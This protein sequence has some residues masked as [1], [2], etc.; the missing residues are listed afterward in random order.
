M[1]RPRVLLAVL[2]HETNTFVPGRTRW[3]DFTV[4]EGNAILGRMD[5]GSPTAGFLEEA[6]QQD[7]EVVPTIEARAAPSG[8]VDDE[9]FERYWQILKD[10]TA[11][12]LAGRID[13]IYLILHGAMATPMLRDVEGELLSRLRA[14]PG[15]ARLP[16]FGV[17]DLHANVSARMCACADALVTYRENP[18]TDASETARRV[19]RMLVRCLAT[20]ELPKTIQWQLPVLLAPSA[21]GTSRDPMLSLEIFARQAEAD[22]AVWACNVAAGFAYCDCEDAGLS[23]TLVSTLPA[24]EAD[25]ILRR[26]ADIAWQLRASSVL[27]H[28]TVDEVI[29]NLLPATGKPVLLV[30]PADNIG[31]GA[32]GDGTAVLR[33]FLKHKVEGTLVIINAPDAVRTLE[34]VAL[35]AQAVIKLRGLCESGD[36][37]E[38]SVQVISRSNGHFVLEDRQSHLASMQGIHI[39]MGPCAVVRCAGT[40]LLL[41][42]RAT[43]PFDLGQLRSQGLEP[44]KFKVIAVKAAVAHRRAYD[45]IAGSS[46]TV[47]TP[48]PCASNLASFAW[49]HLRRPI[50]PLDEF[51]DSFPPRAR[52]ADSAAEAT[53]SSPR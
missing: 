29:A 30:E 47:E 14:L 43:P 23:L 53:P 24:A 8:L 3:K 1:T 26:G 51:E 49:R 42:S 34:V 33:S 32:P 50:F 11:R 15:A 37:L 44:G 48:G 4:R 41:T 38:L 12:Q 27:R 21:T 17:L 16:I 7:F 40:T 22:P 25:A 20:G 6:R 2:F 52:N 9:A 35:G 5:D 19:T 36:P 45:P 31:A 18:H 13:A 10:H 28:P 39:E 46:F